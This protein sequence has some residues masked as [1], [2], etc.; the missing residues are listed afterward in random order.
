MY[1]ALLKE[2]IRNRVLYNGKKAEHI[3]QPK[4]AVNFRNI[5][6]FHLERTKYKKNILKRPKLGS[7]KFEAKIMKT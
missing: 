4:T 6:W 3:T 2:E 1:E 5:S 7:T